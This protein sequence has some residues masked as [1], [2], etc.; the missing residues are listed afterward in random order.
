VWQAERNTFLIHARFFD[1]VFGA[2]PGARITRGWRYLVPGTIATRATALDQ[3]DRKLVD[4]PGLRALSANVWYVV[5]KPAS[6]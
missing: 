1:R 2:L 3:L 5:E 6:T 4:I